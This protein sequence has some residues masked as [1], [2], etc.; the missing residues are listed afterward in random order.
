MIVQSTAVLLEKNEIAP[1]TYQY[2]FEKPENFDFIA[3]QYAFLDFANPGQRDERPTMRA[4]SIASAPYEERLMFVMRDSE[5]AF[6]QNMRNMQI[7]DEIVI[8]GPL[9]HVAIPAI[10][11]QPVVFLVAGVGVTPARSM[12]KQEE[13]IKSPRP[14]T[15]IYSNRTKED[16][17]LHDDVTNITL[18]KYKAVHT[19]TREEGDWNGERG[20]INAE[21]IMRNVDDITNQMYYVV[22]TGEFIVAM[23]GV[24]NELNVP[25]E[26]IVID[27]F[28]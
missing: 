12:I 20:R 8:K 27:N 23:Q 15:L 2:F 3:G 1:Q 14:I 19:L 17:A 21:M 6:K 5:S 9:G 28:G 26:K 7:G 11:H 16:I 13:H 24:L 18:A 22:G 25:K 4:M 10:L